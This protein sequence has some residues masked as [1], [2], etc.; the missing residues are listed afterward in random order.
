VGTDLQYNSLAFSQDGLA[1]IDHTLL[2]TTKD[3]PY[4]V[5]LNFD[6]AIYTVPYVPFST[7]VTQH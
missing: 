1:N 2:I 7:I 3:V 5:F 6:Y 4:N